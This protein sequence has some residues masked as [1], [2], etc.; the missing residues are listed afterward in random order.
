MQHT[1]LINPRKVGWIPKIV[2]TLEICPKL[3]YI[4]ERLCKDEPDI[5]RAKHIGEQ[6]VEGQC[7]KVQVCSD[8]V[9]EIEERMPKT[10]RK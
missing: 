5:R 1:L 8:S 9:K 10:S 3:A 4:P 2:L 6:T 7:V